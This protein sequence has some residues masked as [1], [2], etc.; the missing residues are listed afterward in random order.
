MRCKD[1]VNT[2]EVGN[3][4]ISSICLSLVRYEYMFRLR[5]D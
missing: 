1:V 2:M 4:A 3:E 5:F